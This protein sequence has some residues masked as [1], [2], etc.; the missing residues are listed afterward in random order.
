MP[1][2]IKGTPHVS[3]PHPPTGETDQV[4]S[5]PCE[6]LRL[7]TTAA[8]VSDPTE[9]EEKRHN[10]AQVAILTTTLTAHNRGIATSDS[11]NSLTEIRKRAEAVYFGAVRAGFVLEAA[12]AALITGV[13][14]AVSGEQALALQWLEECRDV[15]FRNNYLELLWKAHVNTAQIAMR[16]NGGHERAQE[17]LQCALGLIVD[18]D[19]RRRH[20]THRIM[21]Q[22][23]HQLAL[24][25]L[26][27]LADQCND[28]H[29]QKEVLSFL[30]VG[31]EQAI[32]RA[33]ARQRLEFIS[34][35]DDD[36]FLF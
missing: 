35:G 14:Q 18:R 34:L 29:A 19:L 21:R 20:G 7:L 27:R 33:D 11:G 5:D 4:R 6:G 12:A 1:T 28:L 3:S 23:F 24:Y 36:L 16:C 17:H 9:P 10:L 26:L 31:A 22:R 25:Q 15:S 30:T 2:L 13:A 32:V 8:I